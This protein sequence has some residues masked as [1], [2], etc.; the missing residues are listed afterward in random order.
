VLKWGYIQVTGVDP[1]IDGRVIDRHA[2]LGHHLI[3]IAIAY[4]VAAI[5]VHRPEHDLAPEVAPFEVR[6]D[7]SPSID[8]SIVERRRICNRALL[9]SLFRDASATEIKMAIAPRP[10]RQSITEEFPFLVSKM[11]PYYDL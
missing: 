9:W 10:S 4:A 5:P 7:P 8:P 11:A 1:P 6:H 2:A 3:E